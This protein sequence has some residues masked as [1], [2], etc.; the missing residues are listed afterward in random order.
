M[1]PPPS[2]LRRS[3]DI[4]RARQVGRRWQH[5]LLVLYVIG[6]PQASLSVSRFAFVAGRHVGRATVRNRAKRRLREI[7]RRHLN[8]IEP[9]HDCLLVARPALVAADAAEL[10]RVVL[11]LLTRAGLRRDDDRGR[12]P[13]ELP[14]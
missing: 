9:G 6:Q 14:L 5:P 10:E 11:L 7:V 13:R 2:R 1:L 4:G 8:T 12:S 3:A